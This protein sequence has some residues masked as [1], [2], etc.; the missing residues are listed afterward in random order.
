MTEQTVIE[1]WGAP[2]PS[3]MALVGR[4]APQGWVRLIVKGVGPR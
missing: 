1:L 4:Y 2:Q 3:G